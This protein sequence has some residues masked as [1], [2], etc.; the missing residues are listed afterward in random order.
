MDNG[1]FRKRA[2][3]ARKGVFI[4]IEGLDG[5]GKTTQTKL[6]VR[7]LRKLGYDAVHTAEPT[8]GKI[9]RYI[10]KHCLDSEKRCSSVVETLLFAA[11]RIEHV[12]T[13][14]APM[15]QT[16]KI[17]VSD[18]Y[19]YSSC[20]YQGATG[21]GLEWIESVNKFAVRPDLALFID[22]Q[23]ELALKRLKAK[24]SVMER[25]ETQRK[26]RQVY[27]TYVERGDLRRIDGGGSLT[28][29]HRRLVKT[30]E[31]FLAKK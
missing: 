17:V 2:L 15:L 21:L 22:V 5:S 25:S 9:G 26:V 1:L 27:Q 10:R 16:G 31:D 11:D 3:M 23:P 20:A 12:N 7:R 18:R 19:V 28:D 8:K 30:V 24:K 4:C 14:I 13:E 29:V 6:L